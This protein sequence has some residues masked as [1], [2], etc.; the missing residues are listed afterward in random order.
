MTTVQKTR[1][2]I[3]SVSGKK[4]WPLSPK[5]ADVSVSDIAHALGYKCRFTGHTKFFYSVAQHSVYVSQMVPR[6]IALP[7]LFHDASEYMLPDVSTPVK[8]QLK[9]FKEIEEGVLDAVFKKLGLMA[10]R[11]D[12][13]VMA[14][15]KKADLK[16]RA[17]EGRDLMPQDETGY[18]TEEP[19]P[20]FFIEPWGIEQGREKFLARY[21][22]ILEALAGY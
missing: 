11:E 10:Y 13:S 3:R 15:I 7:A 6:E 8:W 19:D 5:V 2:Y 21:E 4:L 12:T 1:G 18:S 17:I 20:Y 22:Q 16:L 9:G 14:E